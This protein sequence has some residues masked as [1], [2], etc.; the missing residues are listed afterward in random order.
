[1]ANRARSMVPALE[2]WGDISLEARTIKLAAMEATEE[3]TVETTMA[4]ATVADG[5]R[6][7]GTDVL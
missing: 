4:A 5:A 3:V 7:T 6:I 2:E 1:M